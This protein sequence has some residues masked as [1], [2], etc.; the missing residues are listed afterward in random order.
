VD[1]HQFRRT[2]SQAHAASDDDRAAALF[3]EALRLWRGEPF[4]GLDTP[5]I[6][7]VRATLASQRQAAR[8]DLMDIMLRRGQHGAL[9]ADLSTQAAEHPLDERAA[10]QYMTALYRGGRQADALAHYRR[11]RQQ[12]VDELGADPGSQLQ[13]LRQQILTA[14]P[15]LAADIAGPRSAP[16]I[17]PRQLPADVAQ[18]TGR[19]HYLASLDKL[20]RTV[21]QPG[22]RGT[23]VVISAVSGTAGVGKTALALHWAHQVADRFPDGQL[24]VNLRGY[25]LDQPMMASEALAGFLRALG[26]AGQNVPAEAGERAALYRSL[27]ARRR[28][29]VLLDNAGGVEQV[30]PLLPSSP[31]CLVLV[32]SRDSLAG[33]VA[34]DGAVRLDL[35]VLEREEAA[36]LLQALAGGRVGADRHAAAV[37]AD[38]CSRL[39]LALRVA[40]ELAVAR[41]D[42]PLADLVGELADQQR[43]LDLLDASGD[44]RT[45]VRAVFSWSYQR[46]APDARRVFRLVGLNPGPDLDSYAA[47]LAG[48]T[49]ELAGSVLG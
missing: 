28:M 45:A 29:L 20:A 37:L 22:G 21:G 9:V 19:A 11:I 1:L 47:A 43:R 30:R 16:P 31:A 42:V 7:S 3:E 32:T 12:L 24:Y 39:P 44:A 38:Q 26:V 36:D 25:D 10:A 2:V 13:Q 6:G 49:V 46:L 5:W 14:D 4:A 8:L 23:A 18:F 35:D 15:A 33:L 41:P 34:R 27:L 48:G 40:A 17:A